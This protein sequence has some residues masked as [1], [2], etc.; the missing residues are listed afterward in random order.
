M[1]QAACLRFYAFLRYPPRLLLRVSV[2][3]LF[4]RLP[5]YLSPPMR[6]KASILRDH[7]VRQQKSHFATQPVDRSRFRLMA[8]PLVC[9]TLF[10]RCI[11]QEKQRV[12]WWCSMPKSVAVFTHSFHYVAFSVAKCT[13]YRLLHTDCFLVLYL[14]SAL[15][16]LIVV[17]RWCCYKW[18]VMLS[19]Q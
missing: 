10:V 16:S 12:H 5:L 15:L 6:L 2:A 3:S 17:T 19:R 11:S 18:P 7:I 13:V 14:L 8:L 4:Y 9:A 1:D